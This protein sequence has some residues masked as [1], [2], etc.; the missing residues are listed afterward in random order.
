MSQQTAPRPPAGPPMRGPGAAMAAGMPAEKS[1]DF[2]PSA[3]RLLGQ[4]RPERL[5]ASLVLV[6][7]VVGVGLSVIG[8]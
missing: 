8:P 1:L 4:L 6:L 3:R 2:W 5:Q 7:T